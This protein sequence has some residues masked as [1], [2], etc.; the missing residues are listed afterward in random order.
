M[1]RRSGDTEIVST[2]HG[3]ALQ[4][5]RIFSDLDNSTSDFPDNISSTDFE[6]NFSL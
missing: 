5:R 2:P 4:K 3:T 1:W 6:D